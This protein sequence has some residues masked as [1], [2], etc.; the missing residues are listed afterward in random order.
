MA[1]AQEI[2]DQSVNGLRAQGCKSISDNKCTYRNRLSNDGK[3]SPDS[4][5][6]AVG[7]LISDEE[8]HPNMEGIDV[9][10]MLNNSY[11][12]GSLSLNKRLMPHIGLLIELQAIHD[13]YEFESEFTSWE[14]QWKLLAQKFGLIYTVP[15]K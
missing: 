3:P 10:S 14:G 1:T 15:T 9:R 4:L 8:Y 6:C 13:Q 11:N 12:N 2:F 5:K 7:F